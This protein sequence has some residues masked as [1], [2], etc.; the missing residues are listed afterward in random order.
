MERSWKYVSAQPF[1]HVFL[2]CEVE[3]V[4]QRAV[5]HV[6][7]DSYIPVQHRYECTLR[8]S[9]N[10]GPDRSNPET[11]QPQLPATVYIRTPLR[12]SIVASPCV[13]CEANVHC[14]RL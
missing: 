11:V 2:E 10:S 3:H 8:L 5:A 13:V 9:K 4:G 12:V 1:K 6:R 7:A 14:P